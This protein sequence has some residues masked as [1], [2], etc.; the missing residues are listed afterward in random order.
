MPTQGPSNLTQKSFWNIPSTLGDKCAQNVS[1]IVHPRPPD[2]PTKGLWWTWR[3][4]IAVT[5]VFCVDSRVP[6]AW[7]G[8]AGRLVRKHDHN[9]PAR[10]IKRHVRALAC[11]HPKGWSIW[12]HTHPITFVGF[13]PH[14]SLTAV[15][16]RWHIHDSPGLSQGQSM[17]GWRPQGGAGRGRSVASA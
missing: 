16:R 11:N 10:A 4:R 15:E 3:M 5:I 8:G 13:I 2:N 9:T 1:K 7:G 12:P 17:A 14:V 6:A